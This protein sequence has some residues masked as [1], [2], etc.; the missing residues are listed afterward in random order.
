MFE[1]EYGN[2]AVEVLNI[3]DRTKTEDIQ[4]IPQ[5]FIKF[6]TEIASTE[7]K[8]S[9]NKSELLNQKT[10]E[11]LGVIYINWWCSEKE[12]EQYKNKII[13]MERIRQEKLREKYN[14]N[15]IFA[16]RKKTEKESET[17]A[18][19]GYKKNIFQKIFEKFVGIFKK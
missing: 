8:T 3:L 5:S 1:I 14:P 2:A 10:K 4:K 16:D 11:I 18:I 13:Q 7:Y 9:R 15:N 19:I 6:L 12:K 17:L